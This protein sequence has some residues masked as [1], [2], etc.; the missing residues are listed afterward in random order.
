MHCHTGYTDRYIALSPTPIDV[1]TSLGLAYTWLQSPDSTE[2]N[3]HKRFWEE[4]L[5]T[6]FNEDQW[7]HAC[8]FTHKCSIST[9]IQETSYRLLTNWYNTLFK[10]HK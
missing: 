8:V 2:L 6:V 7:L 4:A 9:R 5:N 3:K 10:L 1:N